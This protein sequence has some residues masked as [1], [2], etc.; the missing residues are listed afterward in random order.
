MEGFFNSTYQ[1]RECG[2]KRMKVRERTKCALLTVCFS[3]LVL[4]CESVNPFFSLRG[5]LWPKTM[6]SK[7]WGE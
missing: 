5:R 1:N 4:S 6:Q 3:L 7:G 2:C